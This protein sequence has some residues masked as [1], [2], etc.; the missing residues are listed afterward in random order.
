MGD[1]NGTTYGKCRERLHTAQLLAFLKVTL[2]VAFGNIL[3][4][5]G[6]GDVKL[7]GEDEGNTFL[8]A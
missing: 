2:T 4:E 6:D 8:P 3:G 1:N 5:P 7:G